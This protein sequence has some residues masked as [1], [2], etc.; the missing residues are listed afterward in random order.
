MMRVFLQPL[1]VWLFRDGRPFDA[2]SDH[3]ARSIFPPLPTVAQGVI[4]SAHLAFRGVP[5]NDYIHRRAPQ[6][7]KEIGPPGHDPP[8][9]LRGPFLAR[10]DEASGDTIRYFPRPADAYLS[11]GNWVALTP[12]A[13]APFMNNLPDGVRLL[14]MGT[15]PDK[16]EDGGNWVPETALR[17]YL[18][19]GRMS[20]SEVCQDAELFVRENRF[21]IGLDDSVR[22]PRE[23]ALY[24]VEFVRLRDS[25]GLEVEVEGLDMSCWPQ[26][27]LLR[28]GG[29][30]R[31][32]MFRKL[33]RE[34]SDEPGQMPE[35]DDQ[36]RVRFKL[37]FA[38]PAYFD[39]GWR[40]SS[41]DRFFNGLTPQ[42]VAAAVRRPL[43][44]GGFDLARGIHK[45][46]RRYVRAG[47]V[48]FFESDGTT[49]LKS[50]H[51]TDFGARIGFGQV[52]IGRW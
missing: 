4:R 12:L 26:S 8:F 31:S 5:I 52:F 44:L 29:E 17:T 7:E 3:R 45:P 13:D 15:K 18:E 42:L 34:A 27:G 21:G 2:L 51:I 24:E 28:I 32:A 9:T 46:A 16:G 6:I 39:K 30:G 33:Q 47:S 19:K 43:V 35:P 25:V 50:E 22:R 40:P 37:Y 49:T 41:W 20:K 48:Y 36:G 11:D 1:D 38:T 14:W 10:W 23:G